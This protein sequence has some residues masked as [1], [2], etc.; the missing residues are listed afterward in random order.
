MHVLRSDAQPRK[1]SHGNVDRKAA[2][3]RYVD[4]PVVVIGVYEVEAELSTIEG[5]GP[6]TEGV[7]APR[8]RNN[9]DVW[10]SGKRFRL[11]A[12]W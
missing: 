10:V 7:W 11:S 6:K 5:A 8:K 2:P 3:F 9:L 12:T 1:R 4:S